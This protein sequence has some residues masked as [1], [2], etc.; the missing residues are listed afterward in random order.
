MNEKIYNSAMKNIK[1]SSDFNDKTL[2][3]LSSKEIKKEKYEKR[4][5]RKYYY[6]VAIACLLIM[7]FA[8]PML[9]NNTIELQ[10]SRGNITVK[11]VDKIP[12]ILTESSL[13][14]LSEDEIFNKYN[15]SIIK[16]EVIDIKNIKI[17]MGKGSE[18]YRAIATMKIL[19]SYRGNEKSGDV[20]KVLLPCPINMDTW[21]SDTDVVSVMS[22]GSIGFFMPI[23]YDSSHIY[24]ENNATLYLA[25]ISEYG[26]MDGERFAFIQTENGVVYADG[27]FE[28]IAKNPSLEDIEKYILDMIE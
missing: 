12:N 10:N 8:I 7:L 15:T 28:S 14:W 9:R 16:G 1:T 20:I 13:V 22:V 3:F 17:E 27:A 24:Q 2:E 26:F 21:V 5:S 11:Y 18:E 25:D 6:G 4:V 19:E 23:K